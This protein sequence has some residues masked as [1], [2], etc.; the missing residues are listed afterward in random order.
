MN[1]LIETSQEEVVYLL[2]SFCERIQ[3][4][5]LRFSLLDGIPEEGLS[6]IRGFL[7]GAFCFWVG[8]INDIIHGNA[9]STLTDEHK[10]A[11][12]WGVICCYPHIMDSQETPSS[13]MDLIDAIDQL[14][15]IEAGKTHPFCCP[16]KKPQNE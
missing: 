16:K 2:L 13:L 6:G 9:S 4:K 8:V 12:L 3:K 1:D 11:L 7:R 10:L 14:L 15:M 5:P